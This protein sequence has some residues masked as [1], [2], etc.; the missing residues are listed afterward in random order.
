MVLYLNHINKGG[1]YLARKA[2]EDILPPSI[3]WNKTKGIQAAHWYAPLKK[4]MNYYQALLK[5]FAKHD[6]ISECVDLNYLKKLLYQFETQPLHKLTKLHKFV[7]L[8]TLHVC[9]WVFLNK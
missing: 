9:E 6:L 5:D 7:L 4:E 1:R 2:I 3:V 8:N